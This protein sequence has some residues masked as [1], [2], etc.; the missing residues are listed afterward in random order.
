MRNLSNLKIKMFLLK[1]KKSTFIK[2]L[3]PKG[4]K[5]KKTRENFRKLN[6]KMS[7]ETYTFI[8]CILVIIVS[9]L[10]ILT[11]SNYVKQRRH[12]EL[13]PINMNLSNSNNDEDV[14]DTIAVNTMKS[15]K[16]K[17]LIRTDNMQ[18]VYKLIKFTEDEMKV[19]DNSNSIAKNVLLK[20]VEISDIRMKPQIV[21]LLLLIGLLSQKFIDAYI[22]IKMA[23]QKVKID[24][25][26]NL[27]EMLTFILVKNT[28]INIEEILRKQQSY[29]KILYQYY[30]ECLNLYPID[31]ELAIKNLEKN[32][33]SQDFSDFMF[34]IKA[35]LTTDRTTNMKLLETYKNLRYEILIEKNTKN[36]DK[37]SRLLLYLSLLV[38][39]ISLIVMF[40]PPIAFTLKVLTNSSF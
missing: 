37:K 17:N 30:Q 34:Y 22:Y 7:V 11:Y 36:N 39:T 20:V 25:E 9:I 1:F 29:S 12:D 21:V 3:M 27:I 4:K 16:Y 15:P 35:N 14:I 19:E 18:G 33:G 6:I 8:K 2:L 28:N 10:L 32:I 5:L 24:D 26:I 38:T 23:L 31:S 13:H 40:A